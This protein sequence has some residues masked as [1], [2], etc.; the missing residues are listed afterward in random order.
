MPVPPRPSS[1]PAALAL[2]T[3]LALLAAP[4]CRGRAREADAAGADSLRRDSLARASTA[5]P[6]AAS[7]P[8]ASDSARPPAT[9]TT[10]TSPSARPEETERG[11]DAGDTLAAREAAR[12]RGEPRAGAPAGPPRPD[13]TRPPRP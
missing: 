12:I 8:A 2:A 7:T 1:V 3:T 13:T 5:P 11:G 4:A 9:P 6:G 10:P